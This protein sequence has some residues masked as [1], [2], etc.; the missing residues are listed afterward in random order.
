MIGIVAAEAF[1]LVALALLY[2]PTVLPP[3]LTLDQAKAPAGTL[4]FLM[5]ASILS[6][7]VLLYFS[8]Y[9]HRVFRGKY[10][11]AVGH[12]CPGRIGPRRLDGGLQPG[13]TPTASQA[14]T[15]NAALGRKPDV[16]RCRGADCRSQR[17]GLCQNP[18][19]RS[20][21]HR[22][23]GV[24]RHWRSRG[25]VARRVAARR[26]RITTPWPKS[27]RPNTFGCTNWVRRATPTFTGPPSPKP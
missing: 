16:D 14:E 2:Y 5:I 6:L 12:C 10:R 17:R 24:D 22:R 23:A 18:N 25:V 19:R 15:E 13:S 9:A 21:D 8:W 11:E 4:N 26:C 20:H 1:G 3:S 7:P 27:A